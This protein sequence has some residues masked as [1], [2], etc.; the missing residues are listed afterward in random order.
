MRALASLLLR[1]I[2][3]LLVVIVLAASPLLLSPRGSTQVFT[4]ERATKAIGSWFVG[5]SDGS[6]FIYLI[7]LTK[8]NFFLTAPRFFLVSLAYLILPGVLGLTL[9]IMFGLMARGKEGG[10]VASLLD[11]LFAIPEFILAL[12]LQMAVLVALDTFGLKLGKISYDPTSGIIL[13]LP[14]LLMS[15][16]PFAYSFRVCARKARDAAISDFTIFARAKGLSE[17]TIRLRHIGAAVTPA[18]EAE[19]PSILALMQ[20]NLFL[21]EYLFALPGITKLLFTAAF[22]GRTPVWTEGYQYQ[23][24]VAVLLGIMLVYAVA[25]LAFKSALALARRMLTGES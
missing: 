25:W 23:L 13:L 3:A 17:K 6:S 8:W 12:V 19:L 24:A 4:P 2:A 16:Y 10:T 21:T 18:M 5:L 1:I 7:G 15:F 14:F 22:P 20:A 9:G 11:T